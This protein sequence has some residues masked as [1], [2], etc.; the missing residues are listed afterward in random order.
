MAD[1]AR[2]ARYR[3]QEDKKL[4]QVR[5]SPEAADG[6]TGPDG[7]DAWGVRPGRDPGRYPDGL[8]A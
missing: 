8:G 1:A 6:S 5:L 7:K 3:A 4:V 2:Q